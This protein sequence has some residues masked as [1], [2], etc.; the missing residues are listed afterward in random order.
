MLNVI[1]LTLDL[2]SNLL[3]IYDFK[4]LIRKTNDS[5]EN[6]CY[7]CL[8]ILQSADQEGKMEEIVNLI[9]EQDYEFQSFKLTLKIP[10]SANLRAFQVMM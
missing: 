10:L 5:S 8:G 3:E 6:L 2:K 4:N 1:S 7:I 9:K